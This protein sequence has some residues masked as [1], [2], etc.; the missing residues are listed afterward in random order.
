MFLLPGGS[1]NRRAKKDTKVPLSRK[2]AIGLLRLTPLFPPLL[3]AFRGRAGGCYGFVVFCAGVYDGQGD[4]LAGVL[5]EV[6][7]VP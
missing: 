3:A 1:R 7:V 2:P 5:V 4:G 6:Y